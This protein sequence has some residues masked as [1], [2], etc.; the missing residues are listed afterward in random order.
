[1][2]P[3]ADVLAQIQETAKNRDFIAKPIRSLSG[4]IF[5]MNISG[6]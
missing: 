2:D 4:L 3:Q 1:M 5:M 6:E